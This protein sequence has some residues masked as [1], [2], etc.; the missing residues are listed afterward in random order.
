MFHIK[1]KIVRYFGAVGGLALCR[2][3]TRNTPKIIM[4]HRFSESQQ[5][6]FISLAAFEKQV[7]YL[8][9]KFNVIRLDELVSR[10]SAGKTIFPNTV[11]ITVDDGYSDFYDIAYPVLKKYS[12]PAT[13]FV[14]TKF[15]DG[16]YWLWPDKVKYILQ[17][18][19]KLERINISNG[20]DVS[21]YVDDRDKLWNI[22][23]SYLLSIADEKKN[24]YIENLEKDLGVNVPDRPVCEYKAINWEQA[25][26]MS[27]SIVEIGAHTRSH[28][29]LGRLPESL[30][31]NEI[32]GSIEDVENNIDIRP[33]TFCY[34]NG[35]PTDFTESVKRMVKES[36]CL[37]A[38]TAFYDHSLTADLFSLRRFSASES[39][40]QFLKVVSGVNV[41]SAHWLKT[42]NIISVVE[43]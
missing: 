5:Q 38:V 43:E 18:S 32:K 22:I 24:I 30:L 31:L 21:G 28:P 26:E 15:V 8:N 12:L 4:Y 25:K 42:D 11:V 27:S 33:K 40:F 39:W 41:L 3:L 2:V 1:S 9:Q 23:V 14:T 19:D 37:G 13:L 6:G 17:Y 34:P 20:I 35:Q 10:L 36:G 16:N 29:S 7:Q